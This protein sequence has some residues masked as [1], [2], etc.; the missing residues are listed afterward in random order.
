MFGG[1]VGTITVT[2]DDPRLASSQQ[3]LVGV[4]FDGMEEDHSPL[5]V[6]IAVETLT[7]I[8]AGGAE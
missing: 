4:L 2:Q 8:A 5:G 3:P 1:R 6:S 7:K